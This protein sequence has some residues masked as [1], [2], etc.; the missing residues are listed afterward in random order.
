MKEPNI[1]MLLISAIIALSGC[2]VWLALYVR[3]LQTRSVEMSIKFT[4]CTVKLENS[5]TCNTEAIE[6]NI[7]SLEDLHKLILSSL[8]TRNKN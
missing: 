8:I 1:V 7:K 4:E 2:I 6:K 3:A 5:I